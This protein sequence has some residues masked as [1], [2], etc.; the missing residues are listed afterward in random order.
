MKILVVCQYYPPE[1]VRIGDICKWLRDR[2]HEVSVITG[3][4]NYPMGKIFDGYGRGKKRNEVID[5]VKIHR[6][7]TIAR[8]SGA[9]FRF[10]N[11]YSFALSSALYASRLKEEYDVVFVN[12]LSPVMMACAGIAYK[13]KH[14]KKLLLYSL[15]L[16]PESLCAGG[17]RKG[18][19]IYRIFHRISGKIYRK[20]DKLLI[21]SKSFSKYFAEEFGINEAIHLPQYAEALFTPETCAKVPD[22]TVDLMFAGNV[23]SAQS[24]DTIIR[25][26]KETEDIQ[27]L[28][29]HIVGDGSELE[30]AK[31]MVEQF[32]LQSV[33]FHGRQPLEE[34]PRFYAMAD[35]MLVTLQKE[36]VISLTLP[37]KVQTYMAAGKP[38]I[39][40]IDGETP[41]VIND[42][43]CGKC[44]AA[45][46]YLALSAIVRQMIVEN[47][48]S[49][50]GKNAAAYYE[51]EFSKE[52]N[53]L[54]LERELQKLAEQK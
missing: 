13:K 38:L 48:F 41:I 52:K 54:F 49:E 28:R 33:L 23:G 4:P 5:G 14:Q 10:L 36:P 26:A 15:D 34:M 24:I 18:S 50:Y 8:R 17:I 16:W 39:G 1:P 44:C 29:W 46:D 6:C 2:G 31:K 35:A 47:R 30:N 11:Y 42:A 32:G 9:L 21:S 45:E 3:V 51:S 40:A 12:Q 53:M 20:V 25:A 27:N 43:N 37:G 19:L 22:E 7:F